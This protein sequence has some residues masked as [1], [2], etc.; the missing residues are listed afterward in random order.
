MSLKRSV[1]ASLSVMMLLQLLLAAAVSAGPY[2][3]ELRE[4]AH[5]STGRDIYPARI[6]DDFNTPESVQA[7]KPG[8]NTK[9]VLYVTSLLNG[10]NQPFEGAG[11]LE[12]M[13]EPVKVYEWRTIYR[14][15]AQPLDLSG[16]RYLALAANSW[17]WQPAADYPLKVVLHGGGDSYESVA[18]I[19]PDSWNPIF[20]HMGDWEGRS[21][22]TKIEISFMQNFDLEGVP[23]GAPGYD[24]WDGRFQVDYLVATNALDLGFNVEGETEGFTS[25]SGSVQATGGQLVYLLDGAEGTLESP[26]LRIDADSRNGLTVTMTNGTGAERMTVQW[27]TEGTDWDDSRSKTFEI[28]ASGTFSRDFN[29]SDRPDWS[30]TVTA[31]RLSV[32]AG[33]GTLAIDQIRPRSMPALEKPY[34]GSASASIQGEGRIAIEGTVSG[35]FAA[36]NPDA[37]LYLYELAT[38][39]DAESAIAANAPLDEAAMSETFRFETDLYDGARSRLY[40]KFAIAARAGDG[41]PT[42]IAAPQYVTNPEVLASNREPFPQGQSIKG[43]QVQMT[44]DAQEL[45]ISHAAL[46]VPYNELMYKDGNHPNNSI[47]Y[48]VEGRTYVFRKDRI[49]QLDR[50]VKSLSDNGI[51]VS[52]ILIMYDTKDPQSANEY[53]IH[54]DAEPGGTVYALNTS[55]AIGVEYVKALTKFLADRYSMPNEPYGRAVNYIVGNEIG[56]NKIW[57]NMGPKTLDVYIREYAQTLRLIDS[58]VK[59]AYANARTYVSLDHYW[60]ENLGNDS[61]WKYDNKE[62]VDRLTQ[63]TRAEGNFGWHMAFHPYPENLF[64]PRFWNDR[65]AVDSFDTER[66]TFKNLDVLVDYMKQPDYLYDGEMRRIILSEQ[67]FHSLSNSEED[68]KIQAAAYAYAYYKIR[69]LDGIDSFILHRHVD[70]AEEGGLN[71]GLWTHAPTTVV[72]PDRHKAIYDVFKYIDTERSLEATDFAKAIIGIPSWEQAIPGFDPAK[73]ADRSLPE[74]HGLEFVESVDHAESDGGFEAGLDGFAASDEVSEVR[75]DAGDAFRGERYLTAVVNS[76][77]RMNWAGVQKKYEQPFDAKKTPYFTAAIQLP[78][79]DPNAE[80]YAKFIVYSGEDTVEGTA[81]LDLSKGWNRLALPLKGWEGVQAV[82]GVKIWVRSVGGAPWQGEIRI[83]EAKFAKKAKEEKKYP[84][85]EVDAKVVSPDLETGAEIAVTVTNFGSAKLNKKLTVETSAGLTVSQKHIQP[86]GI[87][88]DESRAFTLQVAAFEPREGVEPALTLK[89]EDRT[90]AFP[91]QGKAPIQPEEGILF[92]FEDGLQGWSAGQNVASV[93]AVQSFPNGPG[94]PSEGQYALTARSQVAAASA[95]KTVKIA[96]E[97]PFDLS[98]YATFVYDIDSYGGVPGATYET[99]V[100]LRNGADSFVSE[101]PMTPDRWNRIAADIS[102]WPARSSV[103]DIEISFRA[104]GSDMAWNP[105]FQL[106]R[107]GVEE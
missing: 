16:Y 74:K 43:L 63:L 72:T 10:P 34:D 80:Y 42:L 47:P 52:L 88:T 5:V 60:N 70:H 73:L 27:K 44:G 8:A 12:Q 83:D 24:Y 9:S 68:Q 1:S 82:D 107:I 45:G 81:R 91:L 50:Q 39:E 53:L 104:V 54:P 22:V 51:V 103:T 66:I 98:E 37:R 85:V 95:W 102:D 18:F 79:A 67:G 6:V 15:Y 28:P 94:R 64:E 48:E 49:E 62:I 56:Q 84:N 69:F 36:A 86:G 93:S 65:T 33:S 71:L 92:N 2:D 97:Q 17:G 100:V 38:Y 13:P 35:E 20:I 96:P 3:P 31:F 7:W 41:E 59:T 40:S 76:A 26:E 105:E 77:Y 32:P 89:L 14:E 30:G 106:D 78:G 11:A 4:S 23:P 25:P 46:N 61:L 101:S 19:R 29:F 57:N 87:G 58:I 55:N 21:G 90:Y 75:S 99:R